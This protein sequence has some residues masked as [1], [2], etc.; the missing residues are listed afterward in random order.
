MSNKA[1]VAGV[2]GLDQVSYVPVEI[3][4]NDKT[5]G[6]GIHTVQLPRRLTVV[7]ICLI[8]GQ[9]AGYMGHLALTVYIEIRP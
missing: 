6:S 9:G 2:A 4:S 5:P 8:R 7:S 3:V 1:P